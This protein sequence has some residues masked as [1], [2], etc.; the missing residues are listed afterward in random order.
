MANPIATKTSFK[1][2]ETGN[3][4]G[5]PKMD[6]EIKELLNLTKSAYRE[7]ALKYLNMSKKETLALKENDEMSMLEWAFVKCILVIHKKGDYA[8]LDK[9][10]DRVIGKVKD[11]VDLTINP[12]DELMALIQAKKKSDS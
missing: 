11:E 4:G 5:R 6:P 8:T 3:K 9:M 7:I 1:K 12:H 10:M 2:G